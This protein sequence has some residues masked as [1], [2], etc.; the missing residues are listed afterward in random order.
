MVNLRLF[1]MVITNKGHS[2]WSNATGS[3][4]SPDTCRHHLYSRRNSWVC[5][6]SVLRASR[7][8]IEC[9]YHLS[10]GHSLQRIYSYP[11]YKQRERL[12]D[13]SSN[14]AHTARHMG[15]AMKNI[16]EEVMSTDDSVGFRPTNS[17]LSCFSLVTMPPWRVTS[18]T[19]NYAGMKQYFSLW[20]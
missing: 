13:E 17:F 8:K 11:Q 2:K 18:S 16:R 9:P 14:S 5:M 10:H 6:E 3:W 19:R 20:I 12:F 7:V 15:I 4:S 1:Y